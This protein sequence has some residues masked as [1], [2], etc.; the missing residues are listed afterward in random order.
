MGRLQSHTSFKC[1]DGF[2]ALHG[3]VFR[4]RWQHQS[5]SMEHGFAL[6]IGATSHG[7]IYA[8]A[9]SRDGADAVWWLGSLVFKLPASVG[10]HHLVKAPDVVA[11][12][13][14]EKK[15]EQPMKEAGYSRQA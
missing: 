2:H 9:Q 13:I 3:G 10:H 7:A 8:S 12:R 5:P 4:A 14:F 11:A 1:L 15:R 6:R